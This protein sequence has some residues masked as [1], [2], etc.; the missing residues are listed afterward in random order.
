MSRRKMKLKKN[1][2]EGK[3][4]TAKKKYCL[5]QYENNSL[6][7]SPL[8]KYPAIKRKKKEIVYIRVPKVGFAK[9]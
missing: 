6:Q 7:P 5:V 8:I 1:T 3:Y 9:L 4:N 2:I